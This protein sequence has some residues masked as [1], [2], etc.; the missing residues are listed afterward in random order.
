MLNFKYHKKGNE[1]FT[2]QRLFKKKKTLHLSV[3][4]EEE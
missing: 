1:K 3:L 2:N 4:K